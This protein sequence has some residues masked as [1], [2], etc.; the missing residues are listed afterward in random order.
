LAG[1]STELGVNDRELIE[2]IAVLYKE[3]ADTLRV[4]GYA[5]APS[6]GADPLDSY[7]AALDRAQAVAKIL[8]GAGMPANRVQPEATPGAGAGNGRVEI[9]LVPMTTA[10]PAQ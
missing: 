8:G 4:I 5:S 9:Q 1:N 7:R 2:R 10:G 6:A 3:K